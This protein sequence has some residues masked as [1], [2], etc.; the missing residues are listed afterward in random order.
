[1]S[2]FRLGHNVFNGIGRLTVDPEYRE[3]TSKQGNKYTQMAGSMVIN[4]WGK[5]PRRGWRK[6]S[7]FLQIRSLGKVA[8]YVRDVAR[9]GRG[10][11]VHVT[12][13]L[14]NRNTS[15]DGVTFMGMVLVVSEMYLM[16]P[17]QSSGESGGEKALQPRFN[18][19][20]DPVDPFG[21]DG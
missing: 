8:E 1:M 19:D 13:A 5:Q 20:K 2:R 18:P 14:E 15:K 11:L 6:D 10:D 3:K 4:P 16:A 7:V 9:V 21:D 12:G 17:S